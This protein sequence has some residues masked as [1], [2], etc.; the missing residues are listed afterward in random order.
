MATTCFSAPSRTTLTK[1]PTDFTYSNDKGVNSANYGLVE[2]I[3]AGYVMN[4]TD[5]GRGVRL[6]LDLRAEYTADDVNN[7]A[8]DP[9][10][11]ATPN[12]FSGSY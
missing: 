8:F 1:H 9:N 7:L 12:K 3:P 10:G 2:H 4:T 11:N 5:F 6:I